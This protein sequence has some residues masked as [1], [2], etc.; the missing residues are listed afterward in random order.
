MNGKIVCTNH[1]YLTQL[2]PLCHQLSRIDLSCLIDVHEEKNERVRFRTFFL[3]LF[4]TLFYHSLLI[5]GSSSKYR[6]VG[7]NATYI[8]NNRMAYQV[9]GLV[10]SLSDIR[11][12]ILRG[13]K[14]YPN[15]IVTETSTDNHHKVGSGKLLSPTINMA[16]SNGK[17]YD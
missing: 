5:M 17:S 4:L 9:D 11:D 13:N 15:G 7:S 3:N 14:S 6:L 10:F 8:F 16:D 1:I 12:G 2:L